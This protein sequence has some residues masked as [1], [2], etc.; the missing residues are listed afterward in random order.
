MVIVNLVSYL[1]HFCVY[2]VRKWHA[3]I[4]TIDL[5]VLL[6]GAFKAFGHE[7][8]HIVLTACSTNL[9]DSMVDFFTVS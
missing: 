5:R 6:I 7:S 3:D 2:A 1:L 8:R 9:G 4:C